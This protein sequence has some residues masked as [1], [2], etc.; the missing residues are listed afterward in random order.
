VK[1]ILSAN[2]M[3]TFGYYHM[4]LIIE[5]NIFGWKDKNINIKINLFLR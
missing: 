4:T 2:I 1:K 5:K 3:E